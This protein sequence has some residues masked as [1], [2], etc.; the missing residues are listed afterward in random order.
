MYFP[1]N[2]LLYYDSCSNT[3][4]SEKNTERCHNFLMNKKVWAAY[5][6]SHS[7]EKLNTSLEIEL[8]IYKVFLVKYSKQI[9]VSTLSSISWQYLLKYLCVT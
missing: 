5:L 9:E 4:L 1:I 7:F 6:G 2:R 8:G 3:F